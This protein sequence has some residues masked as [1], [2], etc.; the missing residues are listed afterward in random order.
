MSNKSNT[1]SAP[2]RKRS[3]KGR[4]RTFQ[5]ITVII[6]SFIAFCQIFPFYL[7]IVDSLHSPDLIPDSD[8]L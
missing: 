2:L 1:A 6:L 8:K 5:I 4:E 7:K 3:Q